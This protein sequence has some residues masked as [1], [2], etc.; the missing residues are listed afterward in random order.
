VE[1]LKPYINQ[2]LRCEVM[3][4]KDQSIVLSRRAVLDREMAKVREE[5]LASL[6]EGKTVHGGVRSIMPS[7]AFVDI[8]GTDGLL[9]V[10]DMSYSRV[11]DPN[12][13]VKE[14]QELEVM[15]LKVDKETKKVSLGLKQ[16]FPDPWEG[17]AA[18]WAP[19]EVVSGRIT[20]LADFGAFVELEPGVEGLIPISE[21]S[22]ERRLRHP[23][24]V[25]KA[26]DVVKAR[27]LSVD[28]ERKR[29]SLSLKRLGDDPWT[30]AS[31]RW[32]VDSVVTGV[33]KRIVDFGAFVE[34]TGGV[35]GM[36]HISEISDARIPTVASALSEG[37]TVQAKVL[38]VD[39]DRRR[40]ALSIKAMNAYAPAAREERPAQGADQ[41]PGQPTAEPKPEPKRKKPLRGGVDH[42][43]GG[44]TLGN[45]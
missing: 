24:E 19:D 11:S 34:L 27:V 9:H 25:V 23:Q 44:L 21:L 20:R 13:V 14:G 4:I 28:P 26:G 42:P 5:L 7:G 40:I 12:T 8:G 18:K 32:P 22:F 31:A 16:V 29:I 41:A 17:A 10:S 38:S 2:K 30:G 15:I 36:V 1:D 33:V 43:G 39:E 45:L 35:E 37:Q 6:A 3:E